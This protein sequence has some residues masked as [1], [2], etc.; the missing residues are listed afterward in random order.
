ME[1]YIGGY[2]QGKLTYVTD[3]H[4]GEKHPVWDGATETFTG[5]TLKE[6]PVCNHYHLW[7]KRLLKDG[8]DVRALTGQLLLEHPDCI[9]ISD[10]IGNGIVPMEHEEREYR[11]LTEEERKHLQN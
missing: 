5:R 8:A 2:A 6:A 10:E 3:R 1:L 7:V 4:P 11:E 9:I